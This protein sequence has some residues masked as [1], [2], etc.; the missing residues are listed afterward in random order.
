MCFNGN[1]KSFIAIASM[2]QQYSIFEQSTLLLE[3][4]GEQCEAVNYLKSYIAQCTWLNK[5]N[6]LK[7]CA[8]MNAIH[9]EFNIG[10]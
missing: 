9:R 6:P 5:F 10:H 4:W 1:Y 2:L 7:I 3:E 8:K